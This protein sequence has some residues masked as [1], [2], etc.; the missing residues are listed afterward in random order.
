MKFS[1]KRRR[2]EIRKEKT[3]ASVAMESWRMHIDCQ[4]SSSVAEDKENE[5]RLQSTSNIA[6]LTADSA[7]RIQSAAVAVVNQQ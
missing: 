5:G 3:P 1:D 2:K 7:H 4:C 6:S